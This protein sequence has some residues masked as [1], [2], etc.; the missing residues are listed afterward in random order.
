VRL[1]QTGGAVDWSA[2][3]FRGFDLAP[4]LGVGVAAGLQARFQD[5][6]P[7]IHIEHHRVRVLGGDMAA[8]LGRFGLRAEGAYVQS[9]DPRGRDPFVKNR[10]V[11]V[12]A[13][14]DR[15]FG[16]RLNLNVQYLS[17]YVLDDP[18]AGL[19]TRND[20]GATD[21]G[22]ASGVAAQQA[23]LNSQ[24]RHVQHGASFRIA[25][26]WWHETLEAECAAVTYAH[27]SGGAL[28]PKVAYAVTDSWKVLAG[29][30]ILRGEAS[31]LFGLLQGNSTGYAELRW[32]F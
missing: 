24:T 21:G 25:Y 11:F 29:A 20:E 15:T 18:E 9:D 1:E 8:N 27:P 10:F 6:A 26:T 31:S 16:G 19:K 7:V 4:D 2:S 13:G 14:V 17:R 5:Q 28:R 32:S 22:F 23:I 3:Y 12:V 30:E